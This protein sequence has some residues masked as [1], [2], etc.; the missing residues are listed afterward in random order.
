MNAGS[1]VLT[2]TEAR[3][4]RNAH[5]YDLFAGGWGPDYNDPMTDLDL[6]ETGNGNNHTGY[7]SAEYDALIEAAKVETDMVAREQIFVQCEFLL[8]EDMPI[9]PIYWRHEDYA[10]SEK[11][12]EG[13]ARLPFQSYNL[14]YTKLAE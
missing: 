7:S 13:Y 4:R 10:V 14:I 5:N 11:M 6:W 2:I 8:V 3:A 1:E 12:A 9:I